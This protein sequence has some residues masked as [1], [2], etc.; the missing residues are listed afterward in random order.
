MN[1]MKNITYKSITLAK[2]YRT[3]LTLQ[4][5]PP[6]KFIWRMRT[7]EIPVPEKPTRTFLSRN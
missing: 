6:T 2:K 5:D 4:S 7:L 3:I 1:A